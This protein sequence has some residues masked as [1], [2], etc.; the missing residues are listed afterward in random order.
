MDYKLMKLAESGDVGAMKELAMYYEKKANHHRTIGVGE[1]ISVEDFQQELEANKNPGDEEFNA[2]AYEW[3]LKAAEAGDIE[4]MLEVGRR[5]YD[6]IGVEKDEKRAFE[7]YMKAAELGSIQ[8]M[9]TVAHMYWIGLGVKSNLEKKFEWFYKSANLGNE[10]AIR[11][12]AVMYGVGEG[13]AQDKEKAKEWLEKLDEKEKISAMYEI[14]ERTNS[15][16][17][18]EESAKDFV[19][20]MIR[21]AEDYVRK[22]DFKGALVW[23]EKAAAT[24]YPDAMSI[25]GDLYYIGEG[26]IEQD[27]V[28]ALEYYQKAADLNYNMAKIKLAIMIYK[29]LGTRARLPLARNMFRRISMTLET[30]GPFRFNNVARYYLARMCEKGEGS[31]KDVSM[32]Y[33]WYMRA[34]GLDKV[35]DYESAR[36]LPEALYKVADM[37]YLGIGTTQDFDAALE[38]YKLTTEE[39]ECYSPYKIEA[40]KKVMWMYELGEGIEQDKEQ[41]AQWREKDVR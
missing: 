26:D 5:L 20:S 36:K 18:Y 6:A 17:W 9:N 8:G 29:G 30:F 7:W 11:E 4:S 21:I 22:N 24:G 25:I 33:H 19:P 16:E 40:A 27:Y 35:T 37:Q 38:T 12:I 14:G 31:A 1:S 39:G 41:A 10:R 23:Y 28:K 32:A 3:H 2:K 15:I 13:I 34:A